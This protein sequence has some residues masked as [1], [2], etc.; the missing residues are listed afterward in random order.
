MNPGG[1]AELVRGSP[2][3][4]PR[5]IVTLAEESAGCRVA[6]YVVDLDGSVLSR[7]VGDESHF[8]ESISAPIGVGPEIAEAQ[9]EKLRRICDS[10]LPESALVAMVV[11]G[12]ATGALLC[13]RAPERDLTQLAGDAAIALELTGG[14]TDVVHATRRRK[15]IRPA[16]E[17]QADLLPPRL[18]SLESADLACGILPSYD[19]A[20]DFFDYAANEDG[21][22][23]C[24]ADAMGKGNEAAALS[25]LAVGALRSARRGGSTLEQTAA[26]VD[27]TVTSTGSS[28]RF[29]TAVLAHWH[30][31]SSRFRWLNA[32]H[33]PP[34]LLRADGSYEEL[35][36][37]GTYPLGLSEHE[38]DF[39]V[40]E[41]RLGAGE[42][43]LV[44]TDGVTERRYPDGGLLGVEGL[45]PALRGGAEV[46]AA[47]VIR[48]LQ[49][50]VLNA[51]PAPLRD[52]A[53]LLLLAPR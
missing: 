51:S 42:R 3:L 44:Y 34:V 22:W 2:A 41:R 13:E 32:G 29:L 53:T 11:G 12:R 35:V 8:P 18:A 46:P 1:V 43:V 23:L 52:D 14:Y 4:L 28:V 15:E 25:S 20:G 16:A 30:A 33:P 27:A 38:R 39:R 36:G 50:A 40:N 9:L 48:E 6:V 45:A 49:D 31:A 26:L 21:L 37:S 10:R 7:L 47:I 24:V 19:V 17:I 5:R